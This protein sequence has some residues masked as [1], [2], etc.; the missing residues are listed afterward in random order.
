MLGALGPPGA[1]RSAKIPHAS[2]GSGASLCV[3][4][5]SELCYCYVVSCGGEGLG[6]FRVP[7][8]ETASGFGRHLAQATGGTGVVA[9]PPITPLPPRLRRTCGTPAAAGQ[10]VDFRLVLEAGA[11]PGGVGL[12]LHVRTCRAPCRR[13]G[14]RFWPWLGAQPSPFLRLG[15]CPL[16][17]GAPGLRGARREGG[18]PHRHGLTRRFR[19]DLPGR[20]RSV[21]L[22]A[23]RRAPLV[24]G[25]ASA[26]F[27]SRS[28]DAPARGCGLLRQLLPLGTAGA[29][30]SG[31]AALPRAPAGLLRRAEVLTTSGWTG[32]IWSLNGDVEAEVLKRA[33]PSKFSSLV[34]GRAR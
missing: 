33:E 13:L 32:R 10:V 16:S 28:A 6:R 19:E 2:D 3:S 15:A 7:R 9:P 24:W 22:G 20:H 14:R 31:S 27:F 11:R 1:H 21:P 29:E 25:G 8:G 12:L 30:G 23:Q 26:L 34:N 5:S 4:S 18:P 17:G